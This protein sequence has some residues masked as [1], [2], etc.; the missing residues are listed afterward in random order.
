MG[1]NMVRKRKRRLPIRERNVLSVPLQSNQSWSMD[2]MHDT[3]FNQRN[4]RTL[5]VID[6]YN[7]EVLWIDINLSIGAKRVVEV[8]NHIIE[9]RDKPKSIRVDNGPEFISSVFTNWCH[10]HRIEIHYIQPGKPTQNAYIERFNRTYRSEILDKYRFESLAE[11][12]E[13]SYQWIEH[14]N[15]IRPHESLGN[16]SPQ[17]FLLKEKN[18]PATKAL[19]EFFLVQ[20]K[21]ITSSFNFFLV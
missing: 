11:V 1:L 18:S 12:R 21:L 5:N 14:Y 8:L 16:I 13:L 17:I 9:Q 2:F 19:E 10:K 20:Q 4:F 3:L 15:H 6:D 7:R